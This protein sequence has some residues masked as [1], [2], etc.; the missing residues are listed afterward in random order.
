VGGALIPRQTT[1]SIHTEAEV[2]R[3]VLAADV[4]STADLEQTSDLQDE[5]A[6]DR[7]PVPSE[8]S[9]SEADSV[10]PQ[11]VE[12]KARVDSK[13]SVE[14]R[15]STADL[16]TTA[17]LPLVPIPRLRMV[18]FF[19]FAACALIA[20]YFGT[21]RDSGSSHFNAKVIREA[22][23]RTDDAQ[24]RRTRAAIVP[25]SSGEVQKAAEQQTVQDTESKRARIERN[26]ALGKINFASHSFATSEKAVAAVFIVKRTQVVKGR[27]LVRWAAKSGSADAGIDFSDASGTA[28][29]ADGQRQ[30]AIYVPLRNDL[31][32][33][34][35]ETFKVCLR[36]P[37]QSRIDESS[38]AEATIR[39]DDVTSQ[40]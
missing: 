26:V 21:Q 38:C 5:I 36:S 35:D 20:A 9:T 23:P 2:L 40:I 14:S 8:D 16:M 30:L 18:G 10:A 39:D 34:E 32:K 3:G 7:T 4:E 6:A 13:R 25:A 33:E 22:P 1:E 37:R 12:S 31:R 28:R 27:V 29:F 17:D 11:K 15:A 24:V 19:A